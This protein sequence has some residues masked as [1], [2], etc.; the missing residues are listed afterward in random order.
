MREVLLQLEMGIWQGHPK[1]F[2]QIVTF[3]RIVI[4]KGNVSDGRKDFTQVATECSGEKTRINIVNNIKHGKCPHACPYSKISS[5]DTE[6][7][8]L[9]H[10]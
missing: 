5:S 8:L 9:C 10:D 3:L 6:T 2:P 4:G 1:A 7:H